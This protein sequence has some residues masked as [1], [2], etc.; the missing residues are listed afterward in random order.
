MSVVV[1]SYHELL[2]HPNLPPTKDCRICEMPVPEADWSDHWESSPEHKLCGKCEL[3]FETK[4]IFLCHSQPSVSHDALY[5]SLCQQFFHTL[6]SLE[7][8]KQQPPESHF[9]CSMCAIRFSAPWLL[10]GHTKLRHTEQYRRIFGRDA[11]NAASSSSKVTVHH[12]ETLIPSLESSSVSSSTCDECNI[13]FK[14]YMDLLHH[15]LQKHPEAFGLDKKIGRVKCG[16]CSSEF[17]REYSM[18]QHLLAKHPKDAPRYWKSTPPPYVCDPPVHQEEAANISTPNVIRVGDNGDS[19]T[20]GATEVS[21]SDITTS[22]TG[23][24]APS[25]V[26]DPN[27]LDSNTSDLADV[28]APEEPT[29]DEDSDLENWTADVWWSSELD[30]THEE[31]DWHSED[32]PAAHVEVPMENAPLNASSPPELQPTPPP[33]ASAAGSSVISPILVLSCGVCT[34]PPTMPLVTM[35]GHPF[36]HS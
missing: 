1:K 33:S 19:G 16:V 34:K 13:S 35:C 12:A 14:Q 22:L 24:I 11:E 4:E 28:V 17:K 21:A 7:E 31:H 15:S 27:P 20:G 5:C 36:C 3:S 25:I 9:T 2:A 29:S 26:L 30:D 8:H 18:Y 23:G 10:E 6:G 32:V